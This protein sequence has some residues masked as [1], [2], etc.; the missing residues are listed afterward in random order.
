MRWDVWG[1]SRVR[2]RVPYVRGGWGEAAGAEVEL[3][4]VAKPGGGWL[5]GGAM[6]ERA[7]LRRLGWFRSFFLGGGLTGLSGRKKGSPPAVRESIVMV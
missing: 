7:I 1:A 2:G 4:E 6:S 3:A 5:G